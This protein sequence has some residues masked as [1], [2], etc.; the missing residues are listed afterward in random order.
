MPKAHTRKP[1]NCTTTWNMFKYSYSTNSNL[2]ITSLIITSSII[3]CLIISSRFFVASSVIVGV[4]LVIWSNVNT[5]SSKLLTGLCWEVA[6]PLNCHGFSAA[7]VSSSKLFMKFFN[8]TEMIKAQCSVPWHILAS[9][10]HLLAWHNNASHKVHPSVSCTM[11]HMEV[12]HAQY[13]LVCHVWY[14]W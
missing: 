4:V 8:Y 2:I 6:S 10:V 5:S 1:F 11:S 7:T 14:V 13:T 12:H 9:R 3:R